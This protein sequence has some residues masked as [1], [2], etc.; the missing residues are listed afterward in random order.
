MLIIHFYFVHGLLHFTTYEH[1]FYA[2]SEKPL[3]DRVKTAAI[4]FN[5]KQ[6]ITETEKHEELSL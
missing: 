4:T 5:V 1:L 2:H 3:S 6:Y